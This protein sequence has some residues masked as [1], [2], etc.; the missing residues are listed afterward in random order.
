MVVT[1]A[2]ER[3]EKLCCGNGGKT[4]RQPLSGSVKRFHGTNCVYRSSQ[5]N[6]YGE[7]WMNDV[8]TFE[9]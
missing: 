3:G 6:I 4:S 8:Q 2:F 1:N 5:P 9:W 7:I